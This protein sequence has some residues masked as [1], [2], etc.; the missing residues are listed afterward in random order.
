VKQNKTNIKGISRSLDHGL[1][2]YVAWKQDLSESI[3]IWLEWLKKNELL[4]DDLSNR[5]SKISHYLDDDSLSIAFIS[6]FSRGKTELINAIFFGDANQRLLPSGAGRTTMCP[7]KIFYNCD[8]ALGLQ[9]LP[10]ETLSNKASLSDLEQNHSLWT[11]LPF[12]T[13]NPTLAKDVLRELSKTIRVPAEVAT[14]L[15]FAINISDEGSKSNLVEIPKWRH[16]TINIKHPLLENGLVIFDTPGLN[17]LGTET[18]FTIETLQEAH[19]TVFVLDASTGTTGSDKKIWDKYINFGDNANQ[20]VALN[21]LDALWDSYTEERDLR[22]QLK[23]IISSTAS[24]LNIQNNQVHAVSAHNGLIGKI[25]NR[26]RLIEKSRIG[27]LERAI[28]EN[29]ITSKKKAVIESIF[30][31]AQAIAKDID[32]ILSL[33]SIKLQNKVDKQFNKKSQDQSVLEKAKASIKSEKA[34]LRKSIKFSNAVKAVLEEPINE[35]STLLSDNFIESCNKA[36]NKKINTKSELEDYKKEVSSYLKQTYKQ[37][38]QASIK[39]DEVGEKYAA[40]HKELFPNYKGQDLQPLNLERHLEWLIN[41]KTKYLSIEDKPELSPKKQQ[42]RFRKIFENIALSTSRSMRRARNEA[43]DWYKTLLSPY[44]TVVTQKSKI[45][46][47]RISNIQQIDERIKVTV[48]PPDALSDKH[49]K[50]IQ[51]KRQLYALVNNIN[52]HLIQVGYTDESEDLSVNTDANKRN[53][54]D[55]H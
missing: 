20:L 14:S 43:N 49:N 47:Q 28:A 5:F 44:K 3:H 42:Q 31:E 30:P 32:D 12:D 34:A 48:Y 16:A 52:S 40:L 46:E 15:G 19:S 45:V 41:V 36:F 53:V 38:Y 50:V 24:V 11:Q 21:K 22:D 35:I 17:A 18:K 10:I 25:E 6:E 4:T 9:L 7:A 39:A 8:M 23:K 13:S 27:K 26:Q 1:S 55:I 29:L 54:I 2:T 33:Q 37:L 51:Q